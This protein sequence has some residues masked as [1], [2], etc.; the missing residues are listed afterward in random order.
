MIQLLLTWCNLWSLHFRLLWSS[1]DAEGLVSM[2]LIQLLWPCCLLV[3][4]LILRNWFLFRAKSLHNGCVLVHAQVTTGA[5]YELDIILLKRVV[6]LNQL[7]LLV[8]I[9]CSSCSPYLLQ[10]APWLVACPLR[11][12]NYRNI[13]SFDAMRRRS[14]QSNSFWKLATGAIV[15]QWFSFSRHLLLAQCV[16]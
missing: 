13:R 3:Q 14:H 1:V 7:Q 5:V 10:F 2:T 4:S 15:W 11:T 8:L 16:R 12:L 6:C 9:V